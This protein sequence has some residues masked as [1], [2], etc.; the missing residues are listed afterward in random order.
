M[1]VNDPQ[2]WIPGVLQLIRHAYADDVPM[3]GHCLG[4]QLMSKAL[5]GKVRPNSL[6]ELGWSE[7]ISVPSVVSKDWL[8]VAAGETIT[9]YQW[10]GETFDLPMGSELIATNSYCQNQM[11]A[12]GP[13]LGMQCHIEMT[14]AMIQSWCE[15]WDDEQVAP[16]PSV[17]TPAEMISQIERR[18]PQ[19]RVLADNLYG[20]W[21]QPLL[22][23][24]TTFGT[25][26]QRV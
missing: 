9:V 13:H 16:G 14:P 7:L 24:T 25:E 17:Q 6:K 18:M 12:L 21:I 11:F 22:R 2:P 19:L 4:G 1:S 20:H 26:L 8:G 15:Q 23:N 10:H 3:I 5:G